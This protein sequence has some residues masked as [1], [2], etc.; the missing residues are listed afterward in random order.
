MSAGAIERRLTRA[1]GRPAIRLQAV[2]VSVEIL[3]R[4]VHLRLQPFC[5][6]RRL[7]LYNDRNGVGN[8]LHFRNHIVGVAEPIDGRL[9]NRFAGRRRE[10]FR[11]WTAGRGIYI[12]STI[13]PL[14]IWIK[15]YL[16][17]TLFRIVDIVTLALLIFYFEANFLPVH[18]FD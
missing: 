8:R 1:P 9:R 7:L 3:E 15:I 13:A 16:T 5:V 2:A 10:N 18:S 12:K 4:L 11:T 6:S 14:A 17:P